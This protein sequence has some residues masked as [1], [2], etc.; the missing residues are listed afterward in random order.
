MRSTRL[1]SRVGQFY[2]T[3]GKIMKRPPLSNEGNV[4]DSV[5]VMLGIKLYEYVKTNKGWVRN[6]FEKDSLGT[7]EEQ[8]TEPTSTNVPVYQNFTATYSQ[9]GSGP[10]VALAW[11]WDNSTGVTDQKLKRSLKPPFGTFDTAKIWNGSAFVTDTGSIVSFAN[12]T[13]TSFTDTTVANSANVEP[14]TYLYTIEASYGA[15]TV[16]PESA[17]TT[18]GSVFVG[19]SYKQRIQYTENGTGAYSGISDGDIESGGWTDGNLVACAS[20]T[21]VG[22]IL[23]DPITGGNVAFDVISQEQFYIYGD[24][25][26]LEFDAGERIYSNANLS[27]AFASGS[28]YY[29]EGLGLFGS[30]PKIYKS[31][32]NGD[33]T[34]FRGAFPNAVTSIA[35]NGTVGT[36]TIPLRITANTQVTS[37]F[38]LYKRPYGGSWD[39]GTNVTPSAKGYAANTAV[40]TDITVTGLAQSQRYDFKVVAQ[41]L[42]DSSEVEVSNANLTTS[43]TPSPTVSASPS[44]V[45]HT[46]SNSAGYYYSDVVTVTV[47]NGSGSIFIQGVPQGTSFHVP[48]YRVAS[49]ASDKI[50][51]GGS[52]TTAS[53]YAQDTSSTITPSSGTVYVQ[54]RSQLSYKAST[55]EYRDGVATF[56]FREVT[57]SGTDV[58]STV[59]GIRWAQIQP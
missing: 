39:S 58:D 9:T 3:F 2:Q 24:F 32:S 19:T 29:R 12:N 50:T 57:S 28:Y 31:D 27:T 6:I 43:G 45:Q 26:S 51:S 56:N 1:A 16:G 13:T 10:E 34:F 18:T 14:N 33:I 47:T 52:W 41:G 17:Q 54:F 38:V 48:Q 21:N 44:S 36:T 15:S 11:T 40:N 22:S 37:N 59:A 53:T 25:T 5:K 42:T 35:L 23:D 49:S 46:P 4:G 20:L 55:D 8:T 7:A 30:E